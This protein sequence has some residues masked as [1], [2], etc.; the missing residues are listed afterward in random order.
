MQAG[1][2]RTLIMSTPTMPLDNSGD[3]VTLFDAAGGTLDRVRYG[4]SEVRRGVPI[5]F[6]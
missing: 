5:T 4:G 6:D 1:E 3:E 2:R